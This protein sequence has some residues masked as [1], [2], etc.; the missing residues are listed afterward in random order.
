MRNTVLMMMLSFTATAVNAQGATAT[1][2][3]LK[4]TPTSSIGTTTTATKKPSNTGE[5]FRWTD[6][7]GRVQYGAEV[8]EEYRAK[9]RKV[10]STINVVKPPVPANIGQR[11]PAAQPEPSQP[12]ARKPVTEREKCEAAW[13][14]YQASQEC[15]NQ[16]RRGVAGAG[17][18]TGL[19]PEAQN[20][21]KDVTEPAPCR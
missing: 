1:L 4:P 18:G 19:L 5:I 11:A 2:P 6:A 15:F 10:D 17:R 9:A 20:K 7:K 14:E 21:C 12:A 3:A 16:F 13:Q 8:P